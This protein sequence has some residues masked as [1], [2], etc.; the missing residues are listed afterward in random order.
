MQ[1]SNP[2]FTVIIPTKDRARYTHHTLRTCSL[3]EY[4]NLEVI[5]SDDGSTD[6]TRGVVEAEAR[7]DSRIRYVSPGAGVGMLDN[8]EFA[9]SQ[10]KPGCVIALGGDDGLMPYGIAGM[11]DT[12]RDTKQEMLCW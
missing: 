5:V 7:K 3:Q 10:A 12:L 9:L 8:F 6:D 2:R 4:D 11:L 1:D